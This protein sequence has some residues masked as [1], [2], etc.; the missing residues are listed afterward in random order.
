MWLTCF[1]MGFHMRWLVLV[2]RLM[3]LT[4]LML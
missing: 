2:L 4:L 3:R 1:M